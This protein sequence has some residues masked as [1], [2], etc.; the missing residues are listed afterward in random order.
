M[1]HNDFNTW[2]DQW[3]KAQKDGVFADAPKTRIPSRQTADSSFF[4]PS[5]THPTDDADVDN[6]A[7]WGMVHNRAN[8]IIGLDEEIVL[9]E[10]DRPDTEIVDGKVEKRDLKDVAKTLG[11]APNPIYPNTTGKDSDVDDMSLDATFGPKDLEDLADMKIRLHQMENKFNSFVARGENGKKFEG[12]IATL[13]KQI[14][15]LSDL[16]SVAYKEWGL[17]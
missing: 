15:K 9:Q 2:L 4:G 5:D 7:Y 11:K 1:E 17:E 14:D 8:E 13:K 12:Q 3:E 6:V 10:A 16:L